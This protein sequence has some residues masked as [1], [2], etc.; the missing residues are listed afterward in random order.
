MEEWYYI[1]HC[2]GNVVTE[3]HHQ[4]SWTCFLPG[5]LPLLFPLLHCDKKTD[6]VLWILSANA[7]FFLA[8]FFCGC[9]H[10]HRVFTC[11]AQHF[12]NSMHQHQEAKIVSELSLIDWILLIKEEML[13]TSFWLDCFLD[14]CLDDIGF[15]FSLV[16]LYLNFPDTKYLPC[17]PKCKVHI[18]QKQALVFASWLQESSP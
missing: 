3:V 10:V 4:L 14:L 11:P 6:W 8:D 13:L 17:F 18:L 2:P 16:V 9:I 5:L 1:W 7:Y 15:D 12:H